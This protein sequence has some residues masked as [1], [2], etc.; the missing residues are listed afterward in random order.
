MTGCGG[1][2]GNEAVAARKV[3]RYHHH[4]DT[5]SGEWLFAPGRLP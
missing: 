1:H 5:K 4:E 2:A 3:L